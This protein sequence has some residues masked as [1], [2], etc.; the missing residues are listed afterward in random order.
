[1]WCERAFPSSRDPGV[2]IQVYCCVTLVRRQ[3]GMGA[4]C[5]VLI[6][7]PKYHLVHLS[8]CRDY[9]LTLSKEKM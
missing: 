5:V 8:A 2:G 4:A 7:L 6:N 3:A 9:P 1:M